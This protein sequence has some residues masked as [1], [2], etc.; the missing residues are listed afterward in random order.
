VYTIKCISK[1]RKVAQ[2][3]SPELKQAFQNTKVYNFVFGT[4]PWMK[5]TH[6]CPTCSKVITD[7]GE[8]QFMLAEGVCISCEHVRG[9]VED[10][11]AEHEENYFNNQEREDA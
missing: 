11:L 6:A 8:V 7:F 2:M 4:L 5:E 10:M 1:L 9:N 3:N